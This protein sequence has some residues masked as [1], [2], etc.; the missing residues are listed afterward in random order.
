M[1][2]FQ[3]GDVVL[4]KSGGPLMT[5][6]S[7]GAFGGGM[8]GKAAFEGA[9]CVWFEGNNVKREAFPNEVLDKYEG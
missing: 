9:K 1:S 7:V 3:K 6:E 8:S 5:V 2:A 4:L